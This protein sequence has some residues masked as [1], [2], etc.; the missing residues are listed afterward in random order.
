MLKPS[1]AIASRFSLFIALNQRKRRNPS[2]PDLILATAS[3]FLDT[4]VHEFKEEKFPLRLRWTMKPCTGQ[5]V[6]V[7]D[8]IR[9]VT[10][11]LSASLVVLVIVKPSDSAEPVADDAP[12]A[13]NEVRTW[14]GGR[15]MGGFRTR[16]R[17]TLG[18]CGRT[19]LRMPPVVVC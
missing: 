7:Y 18:W 10:T 13:T 16:C 1:R 3:L 19:P 4:A 5:D 17:F 15:D 11:V 2:V 6:V 8:A 14:P 9:L 12:G